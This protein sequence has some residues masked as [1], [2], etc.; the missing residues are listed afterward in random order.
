MVLPKLCPASADEVDISRIGRS[1]L[2]SL[3]M[4]TANSDGIE[5]E[6]EGCLVGEI[7]GDSFKH[8]VSQTEFS[9]CWQS[10]TREAVRSLQVVPMH[11]GRCCRQDLSRDMRCWLQLNPVERQHREHL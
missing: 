8:Q 10:L 6:L 5:G 7:V 11:Y 3:D 4:L 2:D 9:H 1:L